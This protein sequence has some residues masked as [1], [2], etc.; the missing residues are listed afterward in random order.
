MFSVTFPN[1]P[2]RAS[3]SAPAVKAFRVT[4]YV[5]PLVWMF[6]GSFGLAVVA[7]I[8]FKAIGK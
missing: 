4:I 2:L 5:I 1:S 3:E 6:G 7:F 8:F